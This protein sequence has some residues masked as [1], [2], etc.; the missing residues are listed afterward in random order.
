MAEDFAGLVAALAADTRYDGAVT[1]GD[2]LEALRL[3]KETDPAPLAQQFQ[4]V[5]V[6]SVRRAIG[7]SGLGAL[8]SLLAEKLRVLLPTDDFSK[9]DFRD[10]EI[11]GQFADIITEGEAR[12]RLAT[13]ARRTARFADRYGYETPDL[14]LVR[15]AVKLI[16]KSHW[17][18]TEGSAA[19]QQAK[20]DK[21]VII[22]RVGGKIRKLR[23]KMIPGGRGPEFGQFRV[24]V[25][26]Q[27]EAQ[28]EAFVDAKVAS[29]G[30]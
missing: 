27:P 10:P 17:S 23:E 13:L 20:A 4:E 16:A 7:R 24:D 21:A 18:Q 22:N 5:S 15:R 29:E 26:A 8:T 28:R 30:L 14:A 11:R 6:A 19:F 9:I 3:L 2:N 1:S 12:A 25:Y